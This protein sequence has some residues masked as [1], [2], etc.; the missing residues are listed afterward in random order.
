MYPHSDFLADSAE[1]MIDQLF[2][3]PNFLGL[4]NKENSFEVTVD[5]REIDVLHLGAE[6]TLSWGGCEIFDRYPMLTILLTFTPSITFDVDAFY[7]SL[8]RSEHSA[9]VEVSVRYRPRDTKNLRHMYTEIILSL[10]HEFQHMIQDLEYGCDMTETS[11]LTL[12]KHCLND[13]EVDARVEEMIALKKL[14]GKSF[15]ECLS[16]CLNAYFSRNSGRKKSIFLEAAKIEH[17]KIYDYK[18]SLEKHSSKDMKCAADPR[19]QRI[20]QIA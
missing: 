18:M 9:L 5:Q 11:S 13:L 6:T 3:K 4:I 17:Q 20:C 10:V 8:D 16:A 15:K 19:M 12:E 2:R 7:T 14:T 1:S